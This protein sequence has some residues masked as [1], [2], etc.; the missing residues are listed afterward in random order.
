MSRTMVWMMLWTTL[1]MAGRP[2]P[3]ASQVPPG[4]TPGTA[5][6]G[7]SWKLATLVGTD[8]VGDAAPTVVFEAEGIMTGSDGC[9]R[10]HGSWKTSGKVV[11]LTPGASTQMA[12][13]EPVMRQAAAFTKMLATARGYAMDAGQ[14]VLTGANGQRLATFVP[15]PVALL[16]DTPW[17]A[18]MVNNGKGGVSS[19]VKDTTITARFGAGNSL[20][21]SAGCNRYT[22]TYKTDGDTITIGPAATTRKL[23][24]DPVMQ[25]ER[26]YLAALGRT[27]RYRLGD[28]SLEL[29]SETG[30][31]QASFRA[32]E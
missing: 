15:L 14:L 1:L 23:C 3:T 29:R 4:V 2:A 8:L 26:A 22:A 24:P 28:G 30:A 5:L 21:G 25:Q 17:A 19:L 10:Y 18:T 9:N 27:T 6:A 13:P 12:C 32:A 31:L 11:V 7:T 16:R 20:T